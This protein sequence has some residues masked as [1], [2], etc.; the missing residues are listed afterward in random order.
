MWFLRRMIRIP[1]TDKV[2]NDE[3]LRRAVRMLICEIRTRKMRFL[4]RAEKM[5]YG[6]LEEPLGLK[7]ERKFYG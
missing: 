4:G 7:R 6:M 5:I 3:V 1:W 2:S